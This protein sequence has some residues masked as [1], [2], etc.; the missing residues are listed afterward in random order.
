MQETL[1]RGDAILV[2]VNDQNRN[3]N[4]TNREV[5]TKLVEH[6]PTY[7]YHPIMHGSDVDRR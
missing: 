3:M 7:R 5:R 2:S 6:Q 4:V 1:Y